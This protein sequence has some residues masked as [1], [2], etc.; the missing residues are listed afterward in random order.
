MSAESISKVCVGN[1]SSVG[2]L[3]R[4]F[5]T[6]CVD[7]YWGRLLLLLNALWLAI[8]LLGLALTV[9]VEKF[10]HETAYRGLQRC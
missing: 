9:M 2:P 8:L 3:F 10:E 4:F 6:Y 5:L 7:Q 1:N